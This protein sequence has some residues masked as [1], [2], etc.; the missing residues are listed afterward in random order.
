MIKVLVD[1]LSKIYDVRFVRMNFSDSV[2]SAGKFSISK[3]WSLFALIGYTWKALGTRRD[4][5]LYYPPASPNLVPVL[6]DIFFLL[7]TRLFCKGVILH[8][9][10]GGV[11]RFSETHFWLRP[12]LRLAYGKM[13]LGIVNGESCPDDPGYFK[14]KHTVVVPHGLDMASTVPEPRLSCDGAFNIL[15]VGI[16]TEDKGL[17]TLLDTVRILKQRGVDFKVRTVGSWY[18]DEEEK[19]FFRLRKDH[20]VEQAV[21]CVGRK[22]GDDLLREYQRADVLLFPTKYPWETMGIVQLEAMAHGLPVVASDWTGPRDVVVDGIT[23]YLCPHDRPDVFADRLELLSKDDALRSRMGIAG[24]KRYNSM[25]TLE[26]YMKRLE[27]AFRILENCD[28]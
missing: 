8:F 1:N 10:A 12:W 13:A 4:R 16:H 28:G 20:G 24:R 26:C 17:F 18:T 23:G 6:R 9:H 7:L 15:Y 11:S 14:A 25:Y 19:R 5:Y 21:D 3:I 27:K 22:T 2:S